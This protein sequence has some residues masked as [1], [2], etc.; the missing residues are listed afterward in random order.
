MLLDATVQKEP[1]IFDLSHFF[2]RVNKLST[3]CSAVT[4]TAGSEAAVRAAAGL[5]LFH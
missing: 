5:R 2:H 1:L 4:D 3:S